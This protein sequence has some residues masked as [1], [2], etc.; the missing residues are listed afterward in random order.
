MIVADA[1]RISRFSP[2]RPTATSPASP[3]A[4]SSPVNT[5]TATPAA[6]ITSSHCGVSPRW[7]GSISAWRSKNW[8]SPSTISTICRAMSAST[9]AV[10]RFTR[11]RENPRMLR[12]TT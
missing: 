11:V 12:T 8:I 1:L 9:S 4:D 3:D 2:A 6:K 10:I 7:I 5:T